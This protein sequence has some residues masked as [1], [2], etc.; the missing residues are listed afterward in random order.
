MN[1]NLYVMKKS[2]M[3]STLA[4]VFTVVAIYGFYV[5]QRD[6]VEI[7]D[8]VLA[9]IEALA[10]GESGG[11]SLKCYKTVSSGGGGMM[12]HVTYCGTCSAV[13][14]NAYSSEWQCN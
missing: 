14:A 10:S 7:S 13:L 2:L 3:K 11:Q 9:N 1:K 5:S 4:V 6:D 12:T 8:L